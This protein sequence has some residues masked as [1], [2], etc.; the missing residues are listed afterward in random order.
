MTNPLTVT[1][2]G[3]VIQ[4]APSHRW[5]GTFWIVEARYPWSVRAYTTIPGQPGLAYIR[6]TWEEFEIVGQAAWALAPET[7]KE[8]E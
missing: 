6:L 7:S 8:Q 3:A 5:A 1:L 2:D 4:L